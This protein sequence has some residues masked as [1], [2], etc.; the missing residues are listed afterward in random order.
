MKKALFLIAFVGMVLISGC[1][2]DLKPASVYGEGF[3][4]NSISA[5]QVIS[6][7]ADLNTANFIV[8]ATANGGGQSIVG[9]FTQADFKSFTGYDVTYPL[10]INIAN[11]AET[12]TYPIRNDGTPIY[13]LRAVKVNRASYL[14]GASCQGS[15]AWQCFDLY[16]T[17]DQMGL[18]NDAVIKIYRDEVGGTGSFDNPSIK[19]SGDIAMTIA[20]SV[21]SQKIDSATSQSVEFYKDGQW[22]GTAKWTGSLISGNP[23]PNQNLFKAVYSKTRGSWAVTSR[24]YYDNWNSLTFSPVK[25]QTGCTLGTC[26]KET[27]ISGVVDAYNSKVNTL[28]AQNDKISYTGVTGTSFQQTITGGEQNGNVISTGQFAIG[29]PVFTFIVKAK[30]LGVLIPV[31]KPEI[32]SINAPTFSSGDSSGTATVTFKN[33]GTAK[34]SFTASLNVNSPFYQQ[35]TATAISV[36]PGQQGTL[37]LM[38]GHGT[39]GTGTVSGTIRVYDVN[40][41]S[42]YDEET[43][44]TTMTAP[45]ACIPGSF[46]VRGSLV[47]QCKADG[48]GYDM[49]LTCKDG[50]A[51]SY[52]SGTYICKSGAIPTATATTTTTGGINGEFEITYRNWTQ[53]PL[54][55]ILLML[56]A[57]LVV[58]GMKIFKKK[59]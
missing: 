22:F 21:I 15:D 28:L 19:W 52:S 44:T 17:P 41:P 27:D 58:V 4:I 32:I 8:T 5:T 36:A 18:G 2:T 11:V 33:I 46:D 16:D 50:T 35:G 45:K 55:M 40:K 34:A 25:T 51:P 24:N 57:G 12:F 3:T 39:A 47:Y 56:C 20:G 23:Y 54:I 53:S 38:I 13:K 49:F 42:N 14:Q 59:R 26:Y 6:N 1:I 37:T 43:F 10:Q 48:T 7:D 9:T 30:A 31:G 29:Y